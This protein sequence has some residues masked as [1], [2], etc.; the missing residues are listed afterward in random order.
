MGIQALLHRILSVIYVKYHYVDSDGIVI[1]VN[2]EAIDT[3]MN[4]FVN[5]WILMV[6]LDCD[7][8]RNHSGF[9]NHSIP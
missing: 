1:H 8:C 2:N 5:G 9:M 3:H 4:N 7:G 6:S